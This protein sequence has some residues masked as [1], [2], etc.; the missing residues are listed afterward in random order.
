LCEFNGNCAST[1]S[2]LDGGD[3]SDSTVKPD[4]P[5]VTDGGNEG[6][7]LDANDGAPDVIIPKDAGPCTTTS[8]PYDGCFAADG[9]GLFV[10][11]SGADAGVADGTRAKPFKRIGDAVAVFNAA[12]TTAG[13]IYVCKGSYAETVSLGATLVKDVTVF[14][15]L[16][17]TT[18]SYNS[19]Q[20]VTVTSAANSSALFVKAAT[21]KIEIHDVGFVAPAASGTDGS[22]AGNSS[23][24]AFVSGAS[25]VTF[26]RDSFTAGAGVAGT[27][28][29]AQPDWNPVSAPMGNGGSAGGGG[30]AQP[31]SPFVCPGASGQSQGGAGG[32]VN[33]GGSGGAPI[34]PPQPDGNHTG[35]GGA[36]GAACGTGA[37]GSYGSGGK[38]VGG[39]AGSGA[40]S[41]GVLSGSGWSPAN[42]FAGGVGT[43]AQGGGGGGG[44]T[45]GGGGG[46]GQGGCGGLGGG[47]GSGAGASIGLLMFNSTVHL[48]SCGASVAPGVAGG[49]GGK[50][51]NGQQG[52]ARALGG[53]T[54]GCNGGAGGTGGS[55]GGGGGGAGGTSV[56][57]GY[58]STAPT[59]DGTSVSD[60]STAVG[61]IAAGTG[62]TGGKLGTKG[63]AGA[64]AVAGLQ[65]DDGTG[66]QAGIGGAV[67]KLQ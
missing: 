2:P 42:G 14:G 22:G 56:G 24:A 63:A 8:D 37:V 39:G 6:G 66:G 48:T 23:I 25:D 53:G 19:S 27:S 58:L 51:Q 55:G 34:L 67:K 40:A 10:S 54:D 31:L 35:A 36:G 57:I 1:V 26:V 16:D 20:T 12:T 65:G 11:P 30:A 3:A 13:R 44:G 64:S 28:A 21:K 38:L 59:I 52:G 50:G 47:A 45:A 15:A 62:G 33:G 9:T 5:I 17:C 43:A 7:D 46:G 4:S 32:G 60:S 18:W 41:P 29:S 49:D 61:K